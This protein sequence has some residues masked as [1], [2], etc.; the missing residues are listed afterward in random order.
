LGCSLY[1]FVF[2]NEDE[3]VIQQNKSKWTKVQKMI[4]EW[5]TDD[6]G[7]NILYKRSGEERY[8]NFKLYKM[9]SRK[10]HNHVPLH[11]LRNPYFEKYKVS[12]KKLGKEKTI[13]NID[14]IPCYI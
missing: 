9:I 7:K 14:D 5:C 3:E 13:I 8:P 10:V 4:Y 11:V 12:K 1:D 6:L 2:E